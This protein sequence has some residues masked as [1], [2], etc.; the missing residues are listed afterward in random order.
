MLAL[1]PNHLYD[2]YNLVGHQNYVDRAYP[3]R[4]LCEAL[5]V[6]PGKLAILGSGLSAVE[7]AIAT[8]ERYPHLT[9]HFVSKTGQWPTVRAHHAFPEYN[10]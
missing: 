7:V 4:N 2:P 1:G 5:G 8:A 10:S 6:K 9:I 3:L